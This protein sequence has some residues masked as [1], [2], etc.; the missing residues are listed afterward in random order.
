MKHITKMSI[1]VKKALHKKKKT[2]QLIWV[3][4]RTDLMEM[5]YG[6]YLSEKVK[7]ASGRKA[8]LYEITDMTFEAFGM[9]APK[10]PSRIL[11]TLRERNAPK[12]LSV[13]YKA[14]C[15]VYPG[16]FN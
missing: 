5:V 10:N 9:K 6:M 16:V 7:T 4:S 3:G 13:I 11:T 12:K 2:P 15:G 8:T 14:L 1:A